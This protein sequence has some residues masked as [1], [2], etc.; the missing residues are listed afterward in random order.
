M[1]GIGIESLGHL[2]QEYGGD[3]NINTDTA[4]PVALYPS[5]LATRESMQSARARNPL[6][7]EDRSYVQSH[8]LLPGRKY[9]SRSIGEIDVRVENLA[10]SAATTEPGEALLTPL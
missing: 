3:P 4:I 1:K 6:A 9:R 10:T 5:Q 8:T 2:L 7:A